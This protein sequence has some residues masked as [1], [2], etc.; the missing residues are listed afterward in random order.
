M[1][2]TLLPAALALLIGLDNPA[3]TFSPDPTVLAQEASS[4]DKKPSSSKKSQPQKK[5]SSSKPPPQKKSSSSSRPQPQKTSSSSK[6]PPQKKSS[7][8]SRPQ[9]Q[10][11]SSNSKPPP[12]KKSSGSSSPQPQKSNSQPAKKPAES[13]RPTT[14]TPPVSQAPQS[15][16][17]TSSSSRPDHMPGSGN[18][19]TATRPSG[20]G[21][22]LPPGKPGAGTRPGGGGDVNTSRPDPWTQPGDVGSLPGRG[23]SGGS[24]RPDTR[25]VEKPD[26]ITHT[27]S[28]PGVEDERPGKTY[29]SRPDNAGSWSGAQPSRPD[30]NTSPS[31]PDNSG[32]RPDIGNNTRPDTGSQ[33]PDANNGSR[34]G[35]GNGGGQGGNGGGHAR[36]DDSRGHA[37]GHHGTKD[38]PDSRPGAGSHHGSNHSRPH[39]SGRGHAPSRNHARPHTPAH[40]WYYSGHSRP[41]HYRHTTRNVY[42]Y[43]GVWVYGP[44]PHHHHHYHSTH[45]TSGSSTV[46]VDERPELPK[47]SIDRTDKYFLGVTG[48]QYLS[49]YDSGVGFSDAGF[50][51]T[52]GYRPVETVGLELG[53]TYFDQTFDGD[54][55]R[56]TSTLQPSV[57]LYAFPWKRVNPYVQLGG[58]MTRRAYDDSWDGGEASVMG[59]AYGPHAGLG[60]EIALGDNLALDAKGTYIGYM[61]VDGGDPSAPAALQGTVGLDLYF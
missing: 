46:V 49:G 43:H 44:A 57:N 3:D 14:Q 30:T 16:P 48:G 50:G 34:P 37:G 10:K 42:W 52:L 25:P 22:D 9:P 23:D 21:V 19:H 32:Q 39:S 47:R 12:Q 27:P 15:R 17:T 24:T 55:E 59:S 7:S 28:R 11:T 4:K 18:D 33:R 20:G 60:L 35:A 40:R 31:R 13:S 45:T 26:T 53:Y 51:V 5:S 38:R 58:T 61:N 2:T 8:S 36:P 56:Q 54:T 1:S 6:P 41:I 29:P